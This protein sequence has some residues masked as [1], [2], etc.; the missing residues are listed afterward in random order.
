MVRAGA[1]ESFVM[2]ITGHRTTSM[3]RRY[4]IVTPTDM[5]DALCRRREY[6][7]RAGA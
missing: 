1:P 6:V 7:T 2:R 5:I 4:K 3:F